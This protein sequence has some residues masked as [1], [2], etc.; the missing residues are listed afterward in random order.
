MARDEL[1]ECTDQWGKDKAIVSK[2]QNDRN[3]KKD[4]K[5]F[6]V[7]KKGHKKNCRGKFQTKGWYFLRTNS[8]I[9]D[10]DSLLNEIVHFFSGTENQKEHIE[11]G[12]NA[13]MLHSQ[14]NG[15]TDVPDLHL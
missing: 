8:M 12:E 10:C 5:V 9:F 7:V 1:V 13:G 14:E 11:C 4:D 2:H 15:Q 3:T 6:E